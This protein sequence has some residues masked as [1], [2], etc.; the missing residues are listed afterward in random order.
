MLSLVFLGAFHIGLA[1]TTGTE[2]NR[3]STE[4]KEQLPTQTGQ[5]SDFQENLDEEPS[6]D[7]EIEIDQ[8]SIE[9][10]SVNK[11]NFIFYFLYKFKYDHEETTI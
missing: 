7:S 6:I 4:K 9:D 3:V 10:D 11:Y 8:D 5:Q 2:N 1:N